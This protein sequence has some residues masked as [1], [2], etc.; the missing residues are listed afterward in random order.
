MDEIRSEKPRLGIKHSVC[1]KI[2]AFALAVLSLAGCGLSFVAMVAVWEFDM[3]YSPKEDVYQEFCQGVSYEYASRV[4]WTVNSSDDSEAIEEYLSRTN[5]VA[6]EAVCSGQPGW[7]WHWGDVDSAGS[8]PLTEDWLSYGWDN[9]IHVRLRITEEPEAWD[10]FM[11][12]KLLADFCY[13]TRYSI[14]FIILACLAVFVL[15]TVYLLASAGHRRLK[16]GVSPAWT[17]R[18][19]FDLLTLAVF[20]FGV[21]SIFLLQELSWNMGYFLPALFLICLV[22][23]ADEI[24]AFFWLMSGALRIKLGKWWRCTLIFMVL[25]LV[26]RGVKA[27]CRVLMGALQGVGMFWKASIVFV[28]VC[29]VEFIVILATQWGLGA[30]VLLWFMEKM[31]FFVAL[32]YFCRMLS[33][34]HKCGKNVAAGDLSYEPDTRGMPSQF[35]EHASNL[36]SLSGA[37][38]KAVEQRMVSERMKTELITN[39]S[40]DLKTPLTSLINYSDLI[41]REDCDN[42]NH[43]EYAEVLHRQSGRMKRLIDDLVEAS[44]ASSGNMDIE[45]APCRADVL[46]AQAAGEY[47]QRLTELGLA[48]VTGAGDKPLNIMADGRKLWRVMDNLMNNIC[49][50]ALSGTRVYLGLEEKGS[51]VEISFKNTSREMLNLS[52]EELME[53]FVRGDSSRSSEGS[54][55]GLSIARSLTELQGGK[56]DIVCDGDLFKVTLS[57]PRVK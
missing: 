8:G 1:V 55:L 2:L 19:P 51:N 5:I 24:V 50:Y 7:R 35:R 53:R 4:G 13:A 57:F 48:L 42:P 6:V 22:I 11:L 12:M 34:L 56:M 17:T 20:L 26:W 54:G 41:C 45:L 29:I 40:H 37:V 43:R 10:T 3:Y 16:P 46:L 49:K 21:F 31:L 15:S 38:N 9:E 28:C 27:L 30:E 18:I 52:P 25:H 39:V 14:Y 33:E 36:R 47:E 44:K 23:I 32:I